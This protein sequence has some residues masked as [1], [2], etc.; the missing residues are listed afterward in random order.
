M[1]YQQSMLFG[2]QALWDGLFFTPLGVSCWDVSSFSNKSDRGCFYI[3]PTN[4]I[5][6]SPCAALLRLGRF[7]C[8]VNKHFPRLNTLPR[9]TPK[10]S[11]RPPRCHY[12]RIERADQ[13]RQGRRDKHLGERQGQAANREMLP[14]K[15]RAGLTQGYFDTLISVTVN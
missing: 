9:P 10:Q 3:A 1:Y 14:R 7:A 5:A 11:T 12:P 13:V 8:G 2:G 4:N 6:C 15:K